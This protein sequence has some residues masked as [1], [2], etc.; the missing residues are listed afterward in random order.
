MPEVAVSPL[1]TNGNPF[2]FLF[3]SDSKRGVK[4]KIGF[5]MGKTDAEVSIRDSRGLNSPSQTALSATTR[6]PS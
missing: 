3:L 2:S 4:E 1:K 6:C 5:E